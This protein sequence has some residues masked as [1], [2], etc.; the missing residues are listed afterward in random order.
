MKRLAVLGY[1]VAHSR[2]PAM[3]NA[4]LQALGLEREWSYEA[5]EM[6]PAEFPA[7]VPAMPAEGFAG[8]NVTVPHKRAALDVADDA[9]RVAIEIGAA[10]TL[11][12]TGEGIAADNTDAAG[13]MEAI[14]ESPESKRALVLGAGG[15]A[16]AVVWALECSGALIDVWN[17]TAKRA[18]DLTLDLGGAPVED[19]DPTDY[20][21]IVN[22]TAVGL[23]GEDPFAELPLAPGSL[24]SGQL[25]V[26]LVYGDAETQLVRAA[27]RAGASVV[28]GFEVLVQQG[29]ASLRIWTGEDPPLELMRSAARQAR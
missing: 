19:P 27:R 18:H 23:A 4:A 13:F 1:P 25:V 21:L 10:N 17:R 15:A 20:E 7:R 11:S 26:D 14:S 29:A 16:R 8:A 6:T 2:S 22:A 3:Q 5:I 9:S 12:F 24:A 28:D